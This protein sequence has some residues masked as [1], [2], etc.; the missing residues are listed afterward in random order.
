[1]TDK[2]NKPIVNFV[3]LQSVEDYVEKSGKFRTECTSFKI[4]GRDSGG[5]STVYI[6]YCDKQR[7]DFGHQLNE[8]RGHGVFTPPEIG[9]PFGIPDF[10]VFRE[11]FHDIHCSQPCRGY[12]DK[13]IVAPEKSAQQISKQTTGEEDRSNWPDVIL[14]CQWPSLLSEPRI[15][16]SHTVRR[17][18]WMLRHGGPGAVYN[19]HIHD[20]DFGEYE[21]KFPAPVRTLTDTATVLPIICRKAD[22]RSDLAEVIPS[23]DLESLIH[24]PPSGCDVWQYAIETHYTDGAEDEEIGSQ[25]SLPE[26]EIPVTVSYDDKN[27]IRFKIKYHLRYE[28]CIEKGEMIRTGS[29]EKALPKSQL[30]SPTTSTD[31]KVSPGTFGAKLRQ[32]PADYSPTP[33]SV[34]KQAINAVPAVK[35]ALGIG[36]IISVIAIV[37]GF[38][39]DFRV[40]LFGTV[41]MLL[42]MA[43]LLIFAKASSRPESTFKG[44][45][46]ILTWFSL[47][48]FIA[49]ATAL[50]LS[51]FFGK[52]LD[53]RNLLV[54]VHAGQT[55]TE[56]HGTT[57]VLPPTT[58]KVDVVVKRAPS[59]TVTATVGHPKKKLRTKIGDLITEGTKIRDI[60]PVYVGTPTHLHG[61]PDVMAEWTAW[62]AKVEQFLNTNFDAAEVAKFRSLD[63]PNTSL[64]S[65]IHWEIAYLEQLLDR[66]GQDS[67]VPTMNSAPGGIINNGGVINNPTVNN[68]APTQK[69]GSFELTEEKRNGFLKLLSAQ[70]ATRDTVR[71]GCTSWSEK[72]C[73]AAG[74]FL[75]LLSEAGWQIEENKVFR[76]EPQIPIVG[77]AIATHSPADEPKDPLP[78]HQGRWRQMDDSHKTIYWAFRSLDI[79]VGAATDNALKDG[80]LGVYFGSEP[81]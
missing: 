26:V 23:H 9:K 1:M 3:V 61:E 31:D 75:L 58:D 73:V 38:G 55:P 54:P 52:P 15:A 49:I 67:Q 16:G 76:M 21:A 42:L 65:K 68:A 20:I 41:V 10:V 56:K 74:R 24:N 63:D 35:Y 4:P 60:A 22:G 27:G 62:T 81:Q 39:I 45:A 34:L 70:T 37:R 71:I 72:S 36:G 12:S 69:A 77:V 59:Q 53:L 7:F 32:M 79:P 25:D 44:P 6:P 13:R 18:P 40:A 66:V 51:V 2:N 19:V 8:Y 47:V 28:T 57:E 11:H 17:R 46:I 5:A 64:N 50:F 30:P 80:T 78:P 48:L 43:V 33:L 14:E 29:I